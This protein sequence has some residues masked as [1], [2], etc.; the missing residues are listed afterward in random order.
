MP[1][2]SEYAPERLKP[3]WVREPA[4]HFSRAELTGHVNNDLA[5]QAHHPREE[6][7]WSLAAVQRQRRIAGVTGH[8][9][10]LLC[11][12]RAYCAVDADFTEPSNLP[13]N[14]LSAPP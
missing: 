8:A 7:R 3:E 4:Q 10:I 13:T 1:V 6:P 12:R 14:S 2:E 11:S 9:S 5:R